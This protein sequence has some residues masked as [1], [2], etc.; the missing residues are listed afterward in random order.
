M[1]NLKRHLRSRTSLSCLLAISCSQFAVGDEGVVLNPPLDTSAEV[2][3]ARRPWL[4]DVLTNKPESSKKTTPPKP[5]ASVPLVSDPPSMQ[6]RSQ[7]A[8]VVVDTH[9]RQT[10]AGAQA[11]SDDDNWVPRARR[12]VADSGTATDP[13]RLPLRDP[14]PL[15]DPE[16]ASPLVVDATQRE[17]KTAEPNSIRTESP[18]LVPIDR[19]MDKAGDATID[20]SVDSMP[21]SESAAAESS[22]LSPAEKFNELELEL[23]PSAGPELASP[24]VDVFAEDDARDENS[25]ED[26]ASDAAENWEDAERSNPADH[27]S[28]EEITDRERF[29]AEEA[30]A[31][32]ADNGDVVEEVV[33]DLSLGDRLRKATPEIAASPSSPEDPSSTMD[34]S[35]TK[36]LEPATKE[37]S[38]ASD[39]QKRFADSRLATS[40]AAPPQR[41]VSVGDQW[42]EPADAKAKE[43]VALDYV[44]MPTGPIRI[45]AS[46]A[47]MKPVMQRCLSHYYRRPEIANERSNWGMLHSI[48][49]YG[50]DTKIIAE[51]QH[52]SAI[53]WIAGNNA[54]RGQR[55]FEEDRGGIHVKSGVGLQGHQAQMLCVFSLCNVPVDYPL[56]VGTTKYSVR[57]VVKREMADCKSG[58]ELTFTLI[59][60][61]H[62]LDTDESW[63]ASDGTRWDCE[64]LIREELSQPIV[65][66]ACGGTHRLMG[67]AHALRKRRAEGRPITG[68]WARAEE[69]T[70]DFID[71]AFS[72]QN[73]DGSMSTDW[74]EGREDNGKM[75][76]KVQTTGHIVEWLLT[77]M[78]DS[79][80]QDPRLVRAVRYLLASMYNDPNH[81]WQIGPKGHALR[82]LAMYYERTYRSGPAWQTPAV[83]NG[84]R[85]NRR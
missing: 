33:E 75:D 82:A 54:C 22:T 74:F 72:L 46:V 73:R 17:T 79:Q 29:E 57:D 76:R 25:G 71:Y 40:A 43:P 21:T 36:E 42:D 49:V 34:P 80:L 45:S 9:S 60:L 39:P 64:R 26:V 51:R 28:D 19:S 11:A 8:P 30:F 14:Q 1:H 62:Y 32:D 66:A 53:A 41:S 35:S 10:P 15:R 84:T 38:H 6:G 2:Q 50:V 78:P 52:Y 47:K 4:L 20:H 61:S 58:E 16:V 13:K 31:S 67:F 69:F 3:I 81:D 68:Q 77:A 70:N 24:A 63:I 44:G 85:S 27:Y 83:A 55:L 59:A 48:M 18:A 56:Y 12:I 65:G 23:A 7:H 5:P 37:P